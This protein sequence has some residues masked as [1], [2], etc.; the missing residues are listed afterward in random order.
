LSLALSDAP[1]APAVPRP[2]VDTRF[3]AMLIFTLGALSSFVQNEP[4]P[5]D[6]LLILAIGLLVFSAIRLP[7]GLLVPAL[8]ILLILTGYAIG[9]LF[10]EHRTDALMYM[11]TSAFLSISLLFF[12]ALVWSAA[13]R[14]VPPLMAGVVLASVIAALF[15]IAGYFG[16][17]PDA[18]KYAIYGRATG[19]FND[20][21]VFSPSL[22]LPILYLVDRLMH[23]RAGQA[24]WR[25][26][27]LLL[28][29]L[30]LF[31][32]FSRGA[33]G[34][35]ALS[36]LIYFTL[37]YR[38]AR[39]AERT[40][41]VALLFA[42][43]VI[44]AAA[45]A[46]ALSLEEVRSL[47]AQRAVLVQG[48]DAG[49]GGRFESMSAAFQMALKHPL[50]IGPFQWP[51]IWGLM[52]HNIYVNVF[53]SGG[54]IALVGFIGLT[55]TTIVV[56]WRALA[57]EHAFRGLLFIAFAVFIA[58]ALQGFTIDSNH[59]RHLYIDMGLVWGLALAARRT[60]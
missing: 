52:P 45:V 49:E 51:L 21:N 9:S 43:A 42:V 56:G 20:P 34:A 4:A 14:L 12:A 46:W 54:V 38:S 31:L 17:I 18:Q 2:A 23:G 58:H 47:F 5:Y 50:G 24:L 29:L 3:W 55:L 57:Y 7:S 33:W 19:T 39:G 40:R 48:Y 27:L 25:I 28:L 60:A 37:S 59:W 26:P 44:A 16:M 36:S 6:L 15:G 10:A 13:D 30:A 32:S 41:L 1:S 8:C 53:V 11:R 22:I 35:F